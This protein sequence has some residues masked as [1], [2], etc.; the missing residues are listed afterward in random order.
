[1]NIQELVRGVKRR[2]T[3][4]R[5]VEIPC[6]VEYKKYYSQFG[7]DV[8]IEYFFHSLGIKK[9]SYLDIGAF[10]PVFLSNTYK[11]YENGARGVLVEPNIE[12]YDKLKCTR[13][14]DIVVNC[15]V[16]TNDMPSELEFYIMSAPTLS[17]IVH[18]EAKYAVASSAWGKQNIEKIRMVQASTI[19]ELLARHFPSGVDLISIDVEGLDYEI[20]HELDFRRFQPRMIVVE[21]W[22]GHYMKE[23]ENGAYENQVP[24]KTF[25]DFMRQKGYQ[26]LV[27]LVLNGIFI[28]DSDY[29]FQT[30]T[31]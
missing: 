26:L 14:E 28:R 20:L 23:Q 21:I 16:R 25:I 27:P 2:M 19:N 6:A 7:E 18:R 11:L 31:L 5:K 30:D 12:Q 3:Y 17:T 13:P 10:D 29:K 1:M 15:A 9:P 24:A 22:G 4:G 8:I